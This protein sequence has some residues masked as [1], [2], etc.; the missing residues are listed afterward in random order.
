MTND[1]GV[2][3]PMEVDPYRTPS[4]WRLWELRLS[5]ELC[6]RCGKYLGPRVTKR[7][8]ASCPYVDPW[9]A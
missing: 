6:P 7:F 5:T 8:C 1:D 9:T 4:D 3:D 2:L